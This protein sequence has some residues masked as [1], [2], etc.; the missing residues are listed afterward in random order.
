[1]IKTNDDFHVVGKIKQ[2]HWNKD[3]LPRLVSVKQGEFATNRTNSNELIQ[4]NDLTILSSNHGF[5]DNK[6][7][8]WLIE[9]MRELKREYFNDN[10]SNPQ[11]PKITFL[12]KKLRKKVKP[13]KN[14]ET[15]KVEYFAQSSCGTAC[16][17]FGAYY[18]ENGDF[19]R[20]AGS[21]RPIS[22]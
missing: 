1:M 2:N 17:D 13:I 18:S 8:V 20:T 21:W 11:D 5:L 16:D 7:S 15:G 4:L 3:W 9:R 6:Y 22:K 14:E 19:L 12:E 10:V